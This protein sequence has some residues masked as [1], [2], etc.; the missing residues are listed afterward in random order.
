[1]LGGCP[2]APPPPQERPAGRGGAGRQAAGP[3]GWGGGWNSSLEILRK[4]RPPGLLEGGW[5]RK[6]EA[7]PFISRPLPVGPESSVPG[8]R[9]GNTQPGRTLRGPRAWGG[10][11]S[12]P[13]HRR[14][15]LPRAWWADLPFAVFWALGANGFLFTAPKRILEGSRRHVRPGIPGPKRG[16][17]FQV[18]LEATEL[19]AGGSRGARRKAVQP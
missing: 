17:C 13:D 5:L 18:R 10:G 6:G 11:E 15:P 2:S 9:G 4:A 1:M 7:F 19:Q 16:S 14:V 12:G 8:G 3:L